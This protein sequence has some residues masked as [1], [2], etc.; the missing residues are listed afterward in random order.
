MHVSWLD[1]V[2]RFDLT[3]LPGARNPT[4]PLSR[5]WFADGDGPAPSTCDG[6]RESAGALLAPRPS[7]LG[8]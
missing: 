2:F 8:G 6:P 5:R 1:E 7:S 4:D 3:H